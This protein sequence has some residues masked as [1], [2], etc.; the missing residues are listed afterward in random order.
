[1]TKRLALLAILLFAAAMLARPRG[2]AQPRG[3]DDRAY[4]RLKRA[5]RANR[6]FREA[7]ALLLH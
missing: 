5:S 7:H 1:M 6:K 4:L 3:N 2:L